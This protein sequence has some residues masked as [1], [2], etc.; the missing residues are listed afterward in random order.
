[1]SNS[2]VRSET[3]YLHFIQ[4]IISTPIFKDEHQVYG[5]ILIL[6]DAPNEGVFVFP[7]K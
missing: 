1:M 3:V 7:E 2:G 5:L 6:F 4:I